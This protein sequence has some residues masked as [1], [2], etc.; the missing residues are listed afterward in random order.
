MPNGKAADFAM[1]LIIPRVDFVD[2]TL[3]DAVDH[4]NQR[5][6]EL[7]KDGPVYP[8][9]LDPSVDPNAKIKELRIRNCPALVALDYCKEQLK[10]KVT[11][12]DKELRISRP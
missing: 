7:T 1:K 9:V 8:I 4:L 5:A 11:G 10:Y 2:I 12:D 6:R 3:R